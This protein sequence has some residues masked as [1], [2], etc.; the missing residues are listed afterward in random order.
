LSSDHD[1]ADADNPPALRL[2]WEYLQCDKYDK[3]FYGML[4]N[5]QKSDKSYA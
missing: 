3:L 2:W 1:Q 5:M 4:V